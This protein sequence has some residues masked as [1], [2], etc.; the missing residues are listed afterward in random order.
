MCSVYLPGKS[1][2]RE[3]TLPAK[4]ICTLKTQPETGLTEDVLKRNML[5]DARVHLYE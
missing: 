1:L 3:R 2:A 5:K 4:S